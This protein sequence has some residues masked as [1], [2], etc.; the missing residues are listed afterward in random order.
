PSGGIAHTFMS[1]VNLVHL[2]I[3]QVLQLNYQ[4]E[5]MESSVTVRSISQSICV[6]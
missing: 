4:P 6:I 1:G 3:A 5:K 2:A